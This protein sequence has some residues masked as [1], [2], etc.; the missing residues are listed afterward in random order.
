MSVEKQE[1]DTGQNKNQ[2]DY[3]LQ[4]FCCG[5]SLADK[6]TIEKVDLGTKLYIKF[7]RMYQVGAWPRLK[8]LRPP[9]ISIACPEL[10]EL[11]GRRAKEES[12]P[13]SVKHK[14]VQY[15]VLAQKITTHGGG[16]EMNWALF[17]SMVKFI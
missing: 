16:E 17:P 1:A 11:D 8:K 4:I 15:S 13:H 7:C 12:D 5:S 9:S 10:S 3:Y 2:D 14:I 6:K